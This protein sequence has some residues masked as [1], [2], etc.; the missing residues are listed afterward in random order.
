MNSC[1]RKPAALALLCLSGAPAFAHRLDEYLQA[2]LFSIQKDRVQAQMR[3]TPGVAVSAF[4]LSGIDTNGDGVISDAEQRAYAER[5]LRDV[6]LS[7]D[8]HALTPR[9]ISVE[10]PGM[11]EMKQGLGEIQIQF[12]AD[13]PP[14]G[15]ERR[16]VFENHHQSAL[17]AYLVNCLAPRDAEIRVV[18]QDRDE[19][20][21]FY[22]LD[23]VEGAAALE[24]PRLRWWQGVP[25]WPCAAALLLLARFA[26][27][28]RRRGAIR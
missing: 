6:S 15:S 22:Q 23:Y 11:E 8:G 10:F 24:T 17:A 20:Q 3:L 25:V 7:I 9:L 1:S 28:W 19:R 14:G 13:L 5:V 4:I 26:W 2:T 18:Q 12:G 21:S 27:V 16:L